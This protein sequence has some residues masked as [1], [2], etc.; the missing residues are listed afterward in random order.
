[1][2]L[3]ALPWMTQESI[4]FLNN[5]FK[6]YPVSKDRKLTVCEF[7]GG[8]STIYFL[9]KGCKVLTVENDE[10]FIDD[11]NGL[12]RVMK[13]NVKTIRSIDDD[14]EINF[15][16]YDLVILKAVCYEDI[17]NHIFLERYK[18]D[19]VINDGISR[20][21]I[22]QYITTYLKNSIVILDNC[23]YCANWGRLARSSA[24]SNQSRVY[25]DFLRDAT[26][27]KYIF[28][29]QEGRNG[30]CSADAFGWESPN[31]WATAVCWHS[32]HVLNKYMITQLG[33]PLVNFDGIDDGDLQTLETR[34]PYD[35]KNNKWILD[36]YPESLD[37]KLERGYY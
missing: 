26:W 18:W 19:I 36:E 13:L 3:R 2:I 21:D 17:K 22:L 15:E 1:M 12:S 20:P 35:L 4:N 23:E 11:L 8:N 24:K 31:R 33:F 32:S 37:M 34:C 30:Y 5:L 28:E 27:D 6:W 9:Q 14:F 16:K 10:Q 7:G 29:Q 25:R